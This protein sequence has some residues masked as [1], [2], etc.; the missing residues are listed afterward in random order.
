MPE[1]GTCH[2]LSFKQLDLPDLQGPEVDCADPHTGQ[3]VATAQ[4]PEGLTPSS[5]F[6]KIGEFARP[7]CQ[8]GAVEAVGGTVEERRNSLFE[9]YFFLPSR[10]QAARGARWVSCELIAPTAT[11]ALPLPAATPA[12]GDSGLEDRYQECRQLIR[13]EL[14]S[15]AEK[16]VLRA[17]QS[18]EV[19]A[20]AK[21]GGK[22]YLA[23]CKRSFPKERMVAQVGPRYSTLEPDVQL[24]NCL[25]FDLDE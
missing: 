17:T 18:Y 12:I 3:V 20:T 9:T 21:P 10:Q 6:E 14:V 15:C 22:Q 4:L 23:R 16:H 25:A 13:S 11:K 1:V 8:E 7:A 19:P 2:Q 24:V 5:S